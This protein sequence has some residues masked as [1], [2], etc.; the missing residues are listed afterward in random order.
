MVE[1]TEEDIKGHLNNIVNAI[2]ALLPTRNYV[3]QLLEL[4]PRDFVKMID[5]YPEL[6]KDKEVRDRLKDVFGIN[7]GEK[8][9]IGN[10]LASSFY[11]ISTKIRNDLFTYRWK[12]NQKKLGEYLERDLEDLPDATDELWEQRIQMALSEPTY[13]TDCRKILRTMVKGG[14]GETIFDE[15]FHSY[16]KDR[17]RPCYTFKD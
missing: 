13:G 14:G 8:V 16:G 1:I 7:I 4:L 3:L 15:Y 17:I 5:A 2:Y 9:E 12:E 6:F 10:G 11:D